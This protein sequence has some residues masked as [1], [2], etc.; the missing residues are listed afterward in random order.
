[1]ATLT[2]ITAMME[3]VLFHSDAPDLLLAR[4]EFGSAYLCLLFRL[5]ESGHHYLAI[6]IT[7]ARLADLKGG[8]LDL[9]AAFTAPEQPQYFSGHIPPG[10]RVAITMQLLESDVPEE[11]LPQQG[12]LLSEFENDVADG[13]VLVQEA[14]QNNAAVIVCRINPKEAQ[15]LDS[16]VD[17]DR[18]ASAIKKFQFLVRQSAKIALGGR[19][20]KK[21]SP[22]DAAGLHVVAFS[23]GSFNVHFESKDHANLFG[24]SLIGKAMEHIDVLMDIAAQPIEDLPK[25]LEPHR[26]AVMAAYHDLLRFLHKHDLPFAYQWSEPALNHSRTRKISAD[27]AGAIAAVIETEKTLTADAITF[28]GRFTSVQTDRPPFSWTA[29]DSGDVRHY[30]Q[31]HEG[32]PDV[33]NGVIIKSTHYLFAC[34][35]R[36]VSTPSGD[37]TQKLFLKTATPVK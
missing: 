8:K 1:M 34:E 19:T 33:L 29:R 24:E 12:F 15:G 18:L 6:K 28:A 7:S 31:V 27:T 21:N 23:P 25:A 37:P 2:A 5:D 9:R 17:A 30:G 4:D 13:S 20:A 35:Q 36:L 32:F 14:I 26:G 11:W 16:R 3:A 10:E 22:E